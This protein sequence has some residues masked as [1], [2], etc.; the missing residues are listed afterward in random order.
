[1]ETE[2]ESLRFIGEPV[3]VE[4]DEEPVLRKKPG[5]PDRFVWL[6]VTHEVIEELSEWH[7]YSR[8]GRFKRN[9]RP[10]HAAAA[11]RRGSWGVGRDYYR[12]RTGEG[13][14]FE[15][16]YDRAPRDISDRRGSW[17]LLKELSRLE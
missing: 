1:V 12:V 5:C 13:R 17:F 6:G 11:Q 2:H 9:M 15:I 3:E 16:Y 4:F 7:D 14:I 8:R 10:D